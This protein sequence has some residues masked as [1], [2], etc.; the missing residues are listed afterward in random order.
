[1]VGLLGPCSNHFALP[2]LHLNLNGLLN[3]ARAFLSPSPTGKVHLKDN[4]Q[5]VMSKRAQ[6]SVYSP[7]WGGGRVAGLGGGGVGKK[8]REAR[9]AC[10]C[11]SVTPGR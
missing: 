4:F 10:R 6:Q 7:D 1:M 9:G 11:P 5:E 3:L 8:V 2:P